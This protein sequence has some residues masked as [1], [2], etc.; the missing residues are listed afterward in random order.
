M[1]LSFRRKAIEP[2][3]G[4]VQASCCFPSVRFCIA[5]CPE[6]LRGIG[7]LSTERMQ[8]FFEFRLTFSFL[9]SA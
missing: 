2:G 3:R 8:D 7:P 6:R 9:V 1:T 5:A 4:V